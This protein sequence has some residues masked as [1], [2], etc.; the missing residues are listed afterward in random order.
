MKVNYLHGLTISQHTSVLRFLFGF[1]NII[2]GKKTE[3]G[4]Y[5]IYVSQQ[6]QKINPKT[7]ETLKNRYENY[8]KGVIIK[9]V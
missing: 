6:A 5:L 2:K 3:Q 8:Y 4:E 1:E 7:F 9:V